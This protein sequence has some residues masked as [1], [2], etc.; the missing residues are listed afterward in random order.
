MTTLDNVS[1]WLVKRSVVLPSL[2][3]VDC[4]GV[5]VNFNSFIG[6]SRLVGLGEATHGCKEIFKFRHMISLYL[7]EENGFNGLI[8]EMPESDAN[9]LNNYI[10]GGGGSLDEAMQACRYWTLR[11][12]E[13]AETISWMR[14]HNMEAGRENKISIYGCDVEIDDGKRKD[15]GSRDKAMSEK[16]LS[17]LEK[18]RYA[19]WAHNAH[20]A[21]LKESYYTSLGGYLKMVLG[22]SMANMGMVFKEGGF[23]AQN[24]SGVVQTFNIVHSDG[25]SGYSDSF[26]KTRSSLAIFDIR[27]AKNNPVVKNWAAGDTVFELGAIY[28]PEKKVENRHFIDLP[29]KFD[30]IVWIKSITP[31]TLIQ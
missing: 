18:G 27:D 30:S 2:E 23:N 28:D 7:I 13:F 9:L 11:T 22:D 5:L 14:K 8:V 29:N 15:I 25:L 6:S 20:I 4:R 24:T 31:S 17:L 12:T 26:D 21:Y 3:Y 1:E 19:L 10:A 16:V